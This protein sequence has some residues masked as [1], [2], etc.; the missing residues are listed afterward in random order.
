M[1]RFGRLM[2]HCYNRKEKKLS[3]TVRAVPY[4]MNRRVV[5][6]STV[7]SEEG[8]C[9]CITMRKQV[10]RWRRKGRPVRQEERKNF[11][12]MKQSVLLSD[13][14]G[15]PP[16]GGPAPWQQ[17][18]SPREKQPYPWTP[19]D[20]S[21][22]PFL[23]RPPARPIPNYKAWCIY[24]CVNKNKKAT[25]LT[26]TRTNCRAASWVTYISRTAPLDYTGN[27]AYTCDPVCR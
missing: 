24:H 5:V 19:P 26:Q 11:S 27:C 22:S 4:A 1:Y 6:H 21:P 14:T 7:S 17:A 18:L 2:I 10:E 23:S 12:M 3:E 9:E 20:F 15:L 8:P 16:M 13:W 25:R